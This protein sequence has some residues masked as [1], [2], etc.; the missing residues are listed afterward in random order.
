MTS[1]RFAIL[2]LLLAASASRGQYVI[3]SIDTGVGRFMGGM[4]YNADAR[5]VYGSCQDGSFFYIISCDSNEIIGWT[6]GAAATDIV[7][8]S[9]DKKAYGLC[10]DGPNAVVVI[11]GLT[12]QRLRTIDVPGGVDIL[13]DPVGD[14][15]YVTYPDDNQV[16]VI[17]CRT[18]SVTTVIP[19][20]AWPTW[21]ALNSTHRKLYVENYDSESLTIIDLNTHQVVKTIPLGNTPGASCYSEAT[22]RFFCGVGGKC[23]LVDGASDS[24]LA[25][26]YFPGGDPMSSIVVPPHGV[27][28]LGVYSGWPDTIYVLDA[29]GGDVR[30]RLGM[31]SVVRSMVHSGET[32][33]VY[34]ASECDDRVYVVGGD[35]SRVWG[36]VR[37]GSGPCTQVIAPD[38]QAV[39]VGHS[40]ATKVYVIRDEVGLAESGLGSPLDPVL[41]AFPSPF[42]HTATVVCRSPRAGGTRALV[43]SRDGRRVAELCPQ[44]WGMTGC[45]YSWDGTDSDG[46]KLPAGVYSVVIEGQALRA[47]LVKVD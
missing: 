19:V 2:L 4:A 7:Y 31:G 26:R 47:T 9:I 24:V 5:V 39:Y 1:R 40:N 35:G 20:G 14:K 43:Y 17:D 46:R 37:V 30:S 41:T 32:D 8:D 33:Q 22:D 38:F 10:M 27:V 13:W 16:W 6:T 29:T 36:S 15:V 45:R 3:D 28:M 44:P 21:L 18:D 23:V 42:V 11:D 12:Q 25:V 34:C